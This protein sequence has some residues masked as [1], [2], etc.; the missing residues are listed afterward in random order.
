[1]KNHGCGVALLGTL[2]LVLTAPIFAA[3]TPLSPEAQLLDREVKMIEGEFVSL[4][5]AMPGDKYN[6]APSNGEFKGVRTFAQ[7][8]SH[9]GTVIYMVSAGL[10]GEKPP[11]EAGADENGPANLKTKEECVAFA[12]AAF[13]Y[14][15]KAIA[16]LNAQNLTQKAKT[17]YG[18]QPRLSLAN[19]VTW[20]SFDHYGQMVVYA[21]MN[22]IIPPA[23]R[24]RKQ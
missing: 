7:Q 15:H 11:V 24:P 8:V 20:H 6:F 4:A 14:A 5:E 10:L 1:M 18:E 17:P 22:G 16:T 21:R 9:T 23:S 19:M 13:A 2:T 3:D 12:K